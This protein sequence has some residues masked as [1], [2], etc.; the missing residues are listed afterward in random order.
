MTYGVNI[1]V[2]IDFLRHYEKTN[3]DKSNFDAFG[4][5]IASIYNPGKIILFATAIQEFCAQHIIS[6]VDIVN[7]YSYVL[8]HEM[9]HFWHDYRVCLLLY[10]DREKREET[11]AEYFALRYL[12]EIYNDRSADCFKAIYN[13]REENLKENYPIKAYGKAIKEFGEIWDDGSVERFNENKD[14]HINLDELEYFKSE[15]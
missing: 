3:D 12:W 8:A 5:Y 10:H 4:L 13:E 15:N 11:I 9:F 14:L 2:E 7:F 6:G 1:D